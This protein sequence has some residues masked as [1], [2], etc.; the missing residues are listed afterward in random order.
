MSQAVFSDIFTILKEKYKQ[1]LKK[2]IRTYLTQ[3]KHK[4]SKFERLKMML[5]SL[6]LQ[7]SIHFVTIGASHS[8]NLKCKS[9]MCFDSFVLKSCI[10]SCMKWL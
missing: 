10:F 2:I 7:F 5:W 8:S 1:K 9:V 6:S 4:K 3:Q